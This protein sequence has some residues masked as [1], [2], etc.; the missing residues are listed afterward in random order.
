MC[1]R[2]R[3]EELDARQRRAFEE[4]FQELL[5]DLAPSLRQDEAAFADAARAGLRRIVGK[6]LGKRPL[7]EVHI[8]RV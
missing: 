2:D 7:V 5:E 3:L 4:E 8:L 6:P 1:I